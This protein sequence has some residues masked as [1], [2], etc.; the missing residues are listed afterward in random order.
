[1]GPVFPEPHRS[2]AQ[3]GARTLDG[4]ERYEAT[5][6]NPLRQPPAVRPLKCW[7]TRRGPATQ[8][9]LHGNSVVHQGR[10][11]LHRPQ[12]DLELSRT[13]SRF[14]MSPR[15]LWSRFRRRSSTP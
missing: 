7:E 13:R 14:P 5:R 8:F 9:S 15:D 11:I 10:E 4:Q 6:S 12:A 3:N 1:M 2:A